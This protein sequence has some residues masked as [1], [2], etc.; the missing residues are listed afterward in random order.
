M[1]AP[2]LAFYFYRLF[3][4]HAQVTELFDANSACAS[5]AVS[6]EL[7]ATGY[8]RCLKDLSNERGVT[9]TLLAELQ[10]LEKVTLAT[11]CL[12]YA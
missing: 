5:R 6:L 8:G 2:A 7:N 1:L 12:Q 11:I 10:S 9:E 4:K 3:Q